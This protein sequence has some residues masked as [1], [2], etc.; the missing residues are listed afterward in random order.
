GQPFLKH[1]FLASLEDSGS[2]GP[3]TGWQPYHQFARDPDG[4]LRAAVPGYLKQHSF[5]EYVFDMGWADAC[6]RAGIAYYP[7]L[8]LAVSFTPV[9]GARVLGEPQA[10]VE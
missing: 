3:G 10:L 8:L 7:K 6:A 9:A 5:G 1:A 2:V 4:T